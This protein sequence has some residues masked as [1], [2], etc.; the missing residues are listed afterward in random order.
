MIF[1]IADASHKVLSIMVTM[2]EKTRSY[3]EASSP[4][5]ELC[6]TEKSIIFERHSR[7][8]RLCIPFDGVFHDVTEFP[9]YEEHMQKFNNCYNAKTYEGSVIIYFGGD[10]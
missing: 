2:I 3:I 9:I 5:H 8:W 4:Y 7:W 6:R 1:Y 10:Y